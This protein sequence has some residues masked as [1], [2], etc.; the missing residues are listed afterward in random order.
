M[1]P[2]GLFLAPVHGL[3]AARCI[4]FHANCS[5]TLSRKSQ[6]APVKHHIFEVRSQVETAKEQ[7]LA[8]CW[9]RHLCLAT[10]WLRL[11]MSIQHGSFQNETMRCRTCLGSDSACTAMFWTI[12]VIW[13]NGFVCAFLRRA[14][15]LVCTDMTQLQA[16][17]EM[18]MPGIV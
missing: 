16:R 1:R 6:E 13:P 11:Q 17:A 18:Q 15:G 9:M 12:N 3:S 8:A 10:G 2:P 7:L 14:Q 4:N 5:Q